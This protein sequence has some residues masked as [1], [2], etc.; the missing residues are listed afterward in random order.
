[1]SQAQANGYQWNNFTGDTWH[2]L[3]VVVE[4][5]LDGRKQAR[6]YTDGVAGIT[7]R[8]G[9]SDANPATNPYIMPGQPNFD[10]N[11]ILRIGYTP[12]EMDG[13]LGDIDVELKELKIF[14]VAIPDGIVKQYACD[15]T[16]NRSHPYYD[17]LVGYWPMGEGSGTVINDKGPYAANFTLSQ[18]Q[19]NGYQWNNFTDLIC[20][21]VASDL[22]LK[23]PKNSDFP[24]QILSW[25]NISRQ[26]SWALDGKVWITN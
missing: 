18:A 1:L 11:S 26:S 2:D 3:T 19:A 4:T 23:V 6:I 15:Q 21:P 25:F 13:N 16:I 7:N 5:R 20:S 12:G 14:K 9:G 17:Y 10:N 22:S 24:T 8:N